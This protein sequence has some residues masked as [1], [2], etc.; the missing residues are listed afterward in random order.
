MLIILFKVC[1]DKSRFVVLILKVIKW[2]NGEG[3]V[4]LL[5]YVNKII[6]KEGNI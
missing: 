1:K 2:V 3:L 6:E 4:M 5:F